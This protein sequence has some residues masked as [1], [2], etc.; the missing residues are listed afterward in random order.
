MISSILAFLLTVTTPAIPT[1]QVTPEL[2]CAAQDAIRYRTP[3]WVP[4]TCQAVAGAL[5][6]TAAPLLILAII[7]NESDLRP[8]VYAKHAGGIVDVGLMGIRCHLAGDKCTNWP[9]T[10]RTLQNLFDPAVNIEAGSRV[11][12]RKQQ[13][14]GKH[15]LRAYN[16]GSKDHGYADRIHAI[17]AA[18]EGRV[19][20]SSSARIRK[21]ILQLVEAARKIKQS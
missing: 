3:R 12:R 5:N 13:Q 9:V 2:V 4:T 16:G 19:T 7:I 1:A 8:Q 20:E 11:L 14:A 15:F 17:V 21:L 10:G 6:A 18:L